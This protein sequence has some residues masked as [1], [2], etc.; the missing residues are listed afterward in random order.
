MRYWAVV[1]ADT[2]LLTVA[3]GGGVLT[4]VRVRR[5]GGAA[6]GLAG[7]ACGILVVAAI[8]DMVW[9]TRLVPAAID[10]GD[11]GRAADLNDYGVVLTF[12][13]VAVGVGLLIAATNVG[14]PAVARTG[15]EAATAAPA[16]PT[17][18]NH[19]VATIPHQARHAQAHEPAQNWTPPQ[20][21]QPSQQPQPDWNI[22]SGVW[23]IPRGTFDGPPPD[24]RQR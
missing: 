23:S 3:L 17:P 5:V 13:L 24:Q 8:V 11:A 18:P 2:V 19:P 9:W 15:P 1:L 16:H 7:T 21:A 10:D 14:R 12:L 4:L 22:H 20:Q 6:V